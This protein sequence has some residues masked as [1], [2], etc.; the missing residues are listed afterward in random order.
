MSLPQ[1]EAC[2][3]EGNQIASEISKRITEVKTSVESTY[4]ITYE[5][6]L[7]DFIESGSSG[8]ISE[9]TAQNIATYFRPIKELQDNISSSMTSA[10]GLPIIANIT[11][12]RE[13]IDSI[14]SGSTLSELPLDFYSVYTTET[15]DLGWRREVNFRANGAKVDQRWKYQCI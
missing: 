4:G 13:V 7:S 9:A 12:E 8:V 3:T 5:D 1:L 6:I 11:F 2:G 14:F 10:L 15:N